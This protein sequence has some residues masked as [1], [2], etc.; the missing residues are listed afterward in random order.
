M[1]ISATPR[2]MDTL[3]FIRGFQLSQG[4][5]P[6]LEEIAAIGLRSKHKSCAFHLVCGLEERALVRTRRQCARSI[7]LLT[8]VAIPRAPDGAP[9]YFVPICGAE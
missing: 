3:R 4:R 9:L 7:E 5:S 6:T 8:E 1:G 2:Q